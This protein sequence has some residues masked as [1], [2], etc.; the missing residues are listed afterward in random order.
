VGSAISIGG[1]STWKL[2]RH[3]DLLDVGTETNG[4]KRARSMNN[5]GPHGEKRAGE[6]LA[7]V[8]ASL[9]KNLKG[10]GGKL[11]ALRVGSYAVTEGGG[12][13][14]IAQEGDANLSKAEG[15]LTGKMERR[16]V[17]KRSARS[18]SGENPGG[19]LSSGKDERG[20]RERKGL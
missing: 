16:D 20:V 8:E 4:G 19:N 17:R 5:P 1:N 10:K 9:K 6:C 12:E 3:S 2:G 18:L 15:Y 7:E 14:A 11:P 13:G